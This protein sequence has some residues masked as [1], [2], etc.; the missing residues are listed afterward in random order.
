MRAVPELS[1]HLRGRWVSDCWRIDS[2]DVRRLFRQSRR[3]DEAG[4]LTGC[5]HQAP[6]VALK[7]EPLFRLLWQRF[8]YHFIPIGRLKIP[9]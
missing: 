9:K 4:T 1:E 6:L 5:G 2:R 7:L 8:L 3:G